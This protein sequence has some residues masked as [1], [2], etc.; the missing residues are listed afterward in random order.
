MLLYDYNYSFNLKKQF[1]EEISNNI[2]FKE[3][4]NYFSMILIL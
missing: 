1:I 4:S 2:L 3:N